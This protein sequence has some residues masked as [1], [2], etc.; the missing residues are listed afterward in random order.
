MVRGLQSGDLSGRSDQAQ[1]ITKIHLWMKIDAIFASNDNFSLISNNSFWVS[2]LPLINVYC[3]I[4]FLC[5]ISIKFNEY[6]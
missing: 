3:K 4:Q 2:K 1:K 6:G 5:M